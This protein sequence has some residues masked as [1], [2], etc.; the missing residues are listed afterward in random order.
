MSK[1]FNNINGAIKENRIGTADITI[2][3][4]GNPLNNQEITIEQKDH[5]L[6]F[7]CK[8]FDNYFLRNIEPDEEQKE[9]N[10]KIDEEFVELFN[11][12][13]L[14]FYWFAYEFFEGKPNESKLMERAKWFINRGCKV[15]G[16]PLCWH[17]L[18]PKWLLQYENKEIIEKQKKRIER[19]VSAFKGIIDIWDVIN[20]VVI[21]PVFDKYDNGITRIA[22]ELGRVEIVKIMFEKARSSNPEGLF[23]LNDFDL[24]KIM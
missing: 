6:L 19:D 18:T 3:K 21:M 5:K 23:I 14:P 1:R 20:E 11:Y 13:T 7:G 17:T 16:H 12:T 4:D 2:Y 10:K 8:G 15:K 22:K 9:I 24:R